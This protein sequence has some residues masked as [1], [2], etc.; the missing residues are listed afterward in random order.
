M[1]KQ[2]VESSSTPTKDEQAFY[3]ERP[4]RFSPS[5]VQHLSDLPSTSGDSSNA[6]SSSRQATL[7]EHIRAR[8]NSELQ[9]LKQ[10]E[11]EIQEK[12]QR[13]LEKENLDKE[14]ASAGNGNGNASGIKSSTALMQ[15]LAEVARKVEAHRE[16]RDVEKNFPQVHAA[17]GSLVA[18][19]KKNK[20]RPLDCWLEAAEFRQAVKKAEQ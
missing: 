1:G 17:R 3:A 4:V 14:A 9:A 15:E 12:I 13:A 2:G 5:L 19:Y 18:C 20:D 10:Q 11:A 7:D 16:Q 8:I 6:P